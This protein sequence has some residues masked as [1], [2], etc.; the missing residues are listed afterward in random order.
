MTEARDR[1]SV[2]RRVARAAGLV[3][4]LF[5]LSRVTGLV[6][7]MIVGAY[8]GTGAD[9]DAYVAAFRIPDMLFQLVAGG[10]LVSALLP[11]YTTVRTQEG[12]ERGWM[13]ASN[14]ATLVVLTLTVTAALVALLAP[15]LVRH[16]LVPDFPPAQQALT[17]RLLR[18]LLLSTVI[19]GASGLSMSILNA[20]QHFF[21][22]AL[23]PV[24]YNLGIIVGAVFLGR[25]W[26]VYGLAWGVVLGA[27]WHFSIQVPGL[28]RVGWRFRP[29]ISLS[30]PAVRQVLRL[31]GPRVLG[32]AAVQVNFLVNTVLASGLSPGRLSALDYAF[33]VMLL[34]LGIFAQSVA[35]AAF[36][37]FAQ[38]VADGDQEGMRRTVSALL[39]NILFLT[40]PATVALYTLAQPLIA[41]L[42]QRR[43]FDITSTQLTAV[44]LQAYALGLCGHAVVE[45]LARAF[46]A[47]H[48][49]RTPVLI[50]IT[51]MALNI[52]LNLWWI[53]PLGHT[54][55]AL[56]NS[57]ATLIEGGW[58][59]VMLHRRLGGVLTRELG[60]SLLKQVG[61]AL[62]AGWSI[63][64]LVHLIRG[65]PAWLVLGLGSLLGMGTYLAVALLLNSPELVEVGRLLRTRVSR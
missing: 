4:A 8:F 53:H 65:A 33:R 23:A 32:L 37:T 27:A 16:I 40:L 26:G 57:V 11:T 42:F 12:E 44:A 1:G 15:Y 60:N 5:L 24:L 47:L 46:Y 62:L 63:L 36:P 10:A 14:V 25:V 35:T 45:I 22:P 18:V 20:H 29:H 31:M 51:A 54:G 52:L 2:G 13:L 19:F 9:Y 39:R 56:A 48:D 38:Q 7:Q 17:T 3:M 49:T 30:D 58:L 43:A 55:L 50:G 6:R 59:L 34:P 41:V 61:A 64:S 28:Y 21:L